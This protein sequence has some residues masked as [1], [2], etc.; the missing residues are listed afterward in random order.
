MVAFNPSPGGSMRAGDGDGV[1]G[2]EGALLPGAEGGGDGGGVG[3]KGDWSPRVGAINSRIVRKPHV[4]MVCRISE[5]M[6]SV[7]GRSVRYKYAP[8]VEYD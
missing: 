6:L 3:S 2:R 5:T 8:S 4:A 1:D 7:K